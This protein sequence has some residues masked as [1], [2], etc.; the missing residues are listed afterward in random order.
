[1]YMWLARLPSKL[2][3]KSRMH[4]GLVEIGYILPLSPRFLTVANHENGKE[5]EVD[6]I[7][8]EA[9]DLNYPR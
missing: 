7:I 2:C 9:R 8:L 6:S 3:T 1:M 5:A 4:P